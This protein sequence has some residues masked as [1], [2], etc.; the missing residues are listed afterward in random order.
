MKTQSILNKW[1][2]QRA[3]DENDLAGEFLHTNLRSFLKMFVYVWLSL[4]PQPYLL[5]LDPVLQHIQCFGILSMYIA[6]GFPC[7]PSIDD[8]IAVLIWLLS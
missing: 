5:E 8:T 7:V 1:T 3:G 6:S 4:I 2:R